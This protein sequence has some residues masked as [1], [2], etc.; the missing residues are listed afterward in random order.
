MMVKPQIYKWLVL[1]L[2][3]IC[4]V[5]GAVTS[6]ASNHKYK[7]GDVVPLYANKVG[8]FQNPRYYQISFVNVIAGFLGGFF[9]IR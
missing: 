4:S 7:N 1:A 8:P 5:M 2:F 9:P 6:D 3:V